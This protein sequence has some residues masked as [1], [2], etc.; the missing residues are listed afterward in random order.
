[1][2]R[3]FYAGLIRVGL[4]SSCLLLA[5]P[6]LAQQADEPQRQLGAHVHGA[7]KLD[8]AFEKRTLEIELE[9]P[10]NDIVGFENAASTPEQ[11]Q[12]ITQARATLAKPLAII[13]LPDAAG[14]KVVSA[15]VKLVGGGAH[16]HGHGHSHGKAQPGAKAGAKAA[17]SHSEF[18]AEYKFTCAKPELI[19][20]IELDYF[21][22]FPRA[23]KLDV[24]IVGDKIQAKA[25]ATKDKPRFEIKR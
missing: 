4:A 6:V 19:T 20:A 12:A 10:G 17:D 24:S 1:M 22:A 9:A 18:H 13:R 23:E 25:V 8:I 15:K 11:K 5:A 16:D 21:K 2:N 7:G 14:C 3:H